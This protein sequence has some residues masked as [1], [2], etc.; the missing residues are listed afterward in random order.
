[1]DF[2]LVEYSS[3]SLIVEAGENEKTPAEHF[4]IALELFT[5]SQRQQEIETYDLLEVL[6]GTAV[7]D[8]F[9]IGDSR[10]NLY[11]VPVTAGAEGSI[12]VI[13]DFNP[14]LDTVELYLPEDA[15]FVW[16]Q[17]LYRKDPDGF[18]DRVLASDEGGNERAAERFLS[19][20]ILDSYGREVIHSYVLQEYRPN[21]F[22]DA[23]VDLGLRGAVL[24]VNSIID[25]V[26]A[27]ETSSSLMASIR[28]FFSSRPAST[29]VACLRLS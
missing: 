25:G 6:Q 2:W 17:I 4:L 22:D 9:R 10:Q 8:E 3:D 21:D 26:R 20:P 16:D 5:A 24:H 14:F 7:Q 19:Q 13:N 29:K 11:G 27:P 1:M 12:V 28:I 15:S 18:A 23:S